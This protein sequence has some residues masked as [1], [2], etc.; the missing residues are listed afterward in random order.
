MKKE[1]ATKAPPYLPLKTLLTALDALREGV[2]KRIDRVIWRSQSGAVQGQIMIALRFFGLVDDSDLPTMPLLEKLAQGDEKE[3]KALL[4]SVVEKHFAPIISHDL[5]KMTLPMLN[6][7]MEK[8]GLTGSTL[9]KAV[10][11]FLQTAKYLEMPLSPYLIDKTR[12]SPR[13]RRGPKAR[14]S[15]SLQEGTSTLLQ[16]SGSNTSVTLRGGGT[17]T[18]TVTADVWKMPNEDRAFV[19]DLIDKIQAY[20]K[21]PAAGKPKEKAAGQT[22]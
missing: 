18:M 4:K 19:L 17:V 20:E 16:T 13:P 21:V 3:R 15:P 14:N 7:E 10:G 6:E 9:R 22:S 2:P 11:F 1:A 12:N 5:T 8:F